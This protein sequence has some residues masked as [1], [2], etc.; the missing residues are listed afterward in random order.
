MTEIAP[1]ITF[2]GIWGTALAAAGAWGG[3]PLS[4]SSQVSHCPG[5]QNSAVASPL[6]GSTLAVWGY[7]HF[8]YLSPLV[9]VWPEVGNK[10]SG[11]R[12]EAVFS[13]LL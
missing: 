6:R 13:L 10:A 1:L 2:F 9:R 5:V 8:F 4:N 12:S 7:G 11:N 3:R